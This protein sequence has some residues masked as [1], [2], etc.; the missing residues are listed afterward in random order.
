MCP[1]KEEQD[2][3]LNKVLHDRFLEVVEGL[4]FVEEEA[5]AIAMQQ[6][7][8]NQR[9]RGELERLQDHWQR[10]GME[11]ANVWNR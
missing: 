9:T 8:V 2:A 11:L 4:G 5:E 10:A 3:F 6:E 1:W 7:N